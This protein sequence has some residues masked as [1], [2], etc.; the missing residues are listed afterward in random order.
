MINATLLYD[1]LHWIPG[2][3]H[4][5]RPAV[6]A[7][8]AQRWAWRLIGSASVAIGVI[9]LFLPL[10]PTTIFI[11]FGAWAWGKGAPDLKAKLL[12]HPRFGPVIR[13]WEDGGRISRRGKRMAVAGMALSLALSALL[14]GARPALALV[15]VVL[16]TVALWLWR[17]PEPV[18]DEVARRLARLPQSARRLR[19][20]Q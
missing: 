7:R 18:R 5:A 10:L 20:V 11:L 14:I 15:A 13:D 19:S 9:N 1:A 16:G 3:A 2:D 17:R 4:A 6:R 8:A 12:Q